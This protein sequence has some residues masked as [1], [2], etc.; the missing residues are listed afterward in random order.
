VSLEFICSPGRVQP[1]G[2]IGQPHASILQTLDPPLSTFASLT[3]LTF[4]DTR[5][6]THRHPPQPYLP[7]QP[8]LSCARIQTLRAPSRKGSINV[9]AKGVN[10]TGSS[11][12]MVDGT[13]SPAPWPSPPWVRKSQ[14]KGTRG[15]GEGQP[16]WLPDPLRTAR[17]IRLLWMGPA[18][19]A[20]TSGC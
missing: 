7:R 9:L 10:F 6:P 13:L 8:V 17:D 15:D 19:I 4:W 1:A 18:T 11:Y 2:H 14:Q 16:W 12:A 3:N 20:T 5:C